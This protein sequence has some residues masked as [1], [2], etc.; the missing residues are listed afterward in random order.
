M[1]RRSRLRF[2]NNQTIREAYPDLLRVLF[3]GKA[4]RS[5]IQLLRS[6]F[7][8]GISFVLDTTVLVLLTQY[9]HIHYLIAA[10]VGFLFG[11]CLNYLLSIR[12]VFPNRSMESSQKEFTVFILVGIVGLVMNNFF[13]WLFTDLLSVYYIYSKFMALVFVYFWNF[14]ARKF[15]LFR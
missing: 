4:D 5:L 14:S 1:T 10:T 8:G 9:A 2:Y 15:L 7:A 12:W 6:L 3:V 13:L 11:L